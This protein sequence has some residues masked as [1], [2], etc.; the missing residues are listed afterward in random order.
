MKT[1]IRSLLATTAFAAV[2]GFF[3]HTASAQDSDRA[4]FRERALTRYRE[5]L[6]VKSD[7]DW[8]KLE[9]LV[10][11]VMDARTA[12]GFGFGG[13]GGRGGGGRGGG[14]GG[15][16]G[17]EGEQANRNRF[18][19]PSPEEQALDKAIEAKAPADEV[20]TKLAA[21]RESRK[22]KEAALEQAQEE[23]RKALSPRQEAA[24]VLARLVK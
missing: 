1:N 14:G 3:T 2:L 22:A 24:A 23:L 10:G 13:R 15:G 9:P 4:Q 6:D 16:G 17:G 5:Q 19:S 7:E 11:K 21:V 20:K 18:G 8:K 12:V